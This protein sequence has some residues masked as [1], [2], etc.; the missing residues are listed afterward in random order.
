M[1]M[2]ID[3]ETPWIPKQQQQQ[4]RPFLDKSSACQ[5]I[6]SKELQDILYTVGDGSIYW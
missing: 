5:E 1:T 6:S 2:T 4:Q 3:V